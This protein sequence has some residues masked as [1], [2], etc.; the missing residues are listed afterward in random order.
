VIGTTYD[1]AT[2]YQSAVALSHQLSRGRLLTVDGYGHT[3]GASTCAHRYETRY[4][5]SGALPRRGARCSQDKR[6]FTG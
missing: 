6:P 4:L 3:S 5:I 1:P 2:P